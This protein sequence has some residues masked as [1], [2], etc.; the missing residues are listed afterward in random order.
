MPEKLR[1]EDGTEI[2]GRALKSDGRL[3]LYAYGIDTLRAWFGLVDDAEKT[4]QITYVMLGGEEK[5]YAG[6]TR[7]IAVRDEGDGL[8][9]AVL[10]RDE[11]V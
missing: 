3:F 1:L 10:G 5:T 11:N 9:T 7:L 2:A 8:L 4:A 6:F